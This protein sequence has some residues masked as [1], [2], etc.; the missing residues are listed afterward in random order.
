MYLKERKIANLYLQDSVCLEHK[1]EST[2]KSF[3]QL[4]IATVVTFL[5]SGRQVWTGRFITP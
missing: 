4:Q 5:M 1:F 2:P 3:P